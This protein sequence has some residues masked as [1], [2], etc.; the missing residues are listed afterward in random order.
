MKRARS[1]SNSE[2]DESWIEEI[3]KHETYAITEVYNKP[4]FEYRFGFYRY[5]T[6]MS[7]EFHNNP[8]V[9]CE[10][11]THPMR[12]IWP[13]ILSRVHKLNL[14][15]EWLNGRIQ[16]FRAISLA[17]A[18]NVNKVKVAKV[19]ILTKFNYSGTISSEDMFAKWWK[20]IESVQKLQLNSTCKLTCTYYS[21]LTKRPNRW[22]HY[23]FA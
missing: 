13:N 3:V 8:R 6:I 11:D 12:E 1:P 7:I 4:L 22:Y 10:N 14:L 15:D 20:F 17:N 16:I 9:R 19:A 5:R 18:S 21:V 2:S 23:V